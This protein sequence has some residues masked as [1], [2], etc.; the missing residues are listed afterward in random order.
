ME[1][2]VDCG[3]GVGRR[4]TERVGETGER[5][6]GKFEARVIMGPPNT[7]SRPVRLRV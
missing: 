2:K 3:G 1:E 7:G 5:G 4:V 6:E